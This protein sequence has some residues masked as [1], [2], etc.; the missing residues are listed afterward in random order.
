MTERFYCVN[1]KRF[2]GLSTN[3]R[4]ENCD[5]DS[6]VSEHTLAASLGISDVAKPGGERHED[7]GLRRRDN[8]SA[9]DKKTSTSSP[10]EA[11]A[12]DSHEADAIRA[13]LRLHGFAEIAQQWDGWLWEL[14]HDNAN[15]VA[16]S[17]AASGVFGKTHCSQ[18]VLSNHD[19]DFTEFVFQ[20]RW[21]SVAVDFVKDEDEDE[22]SS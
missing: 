4:C 8:L 13:F 19:E 9:S 15:D 21:N 7:T 16:D 17:V 2:V 1:C 12:R 18:L 22:R 11:D 5:S 10:R 6:V 3:G 20:L 14:S